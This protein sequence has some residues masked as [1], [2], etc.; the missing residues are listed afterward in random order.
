MELLN[1][2]WITF[3]TLTSLT[4]VVPMSNWL[5]STSRFNHT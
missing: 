4:E 5:D 3:P 2:S 1:R